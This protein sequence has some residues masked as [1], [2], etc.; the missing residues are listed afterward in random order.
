M[1]GIT[2]FVPGEE[3]I[4]GKVYWSIDDILCF[5]LELTDRKGGKDAKPAL[6]GDYGSDIGVDPRIETGNLVKFI[7]LDAYSGLWTIAGT[8]LNLSKIEAA[9]RRVKFNRAFANSKD[10]YHLTPELWMKELATQ[11]RLRVIASEHTIDPAP[12]CELQR[13]S[14]SILHWLR[15]D[16]E[17]LMQL[18]AA[19]FERLLMTLIDKMGYHVKSVGDTHQ[20]DGGIDIVAWPEYGLPHIVA[21]Q[22]KHHR[23][24]GN[25][26]VGDVRNFLGA[27]KANPV[28]SF[29]LL[30]TNTSFTADAKS[31]ADKVATKIRLRS[32][33]DLVGWLN[34]DLA[35][36]ADWL[37]EEIDI[38]LGVTTKLTSSPKLTDMSREVNRARMVLDMFLPHDEDTREPF[39]KMFEIDGNNRERP[40]R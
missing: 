14:T 7:Q 4:A 28:F 5:N 12:I 36:E 15:E 25:T 31:F 18:N 2:N 22:A 11:T 6:A 8:E 9:V 23:V 19:S 3:A 10:K 17:R 39:G 21:I 27:L 32:G 1:A 38:A 40:S 20:K 26:S 16:Q 30:V 24:K 13:F 34:N 33:Q 37:P 29:G 35:S